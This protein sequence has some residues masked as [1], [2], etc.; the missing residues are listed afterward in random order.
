[1]VPSLRAGSLLGR[2]LFCARPQLR[3]YSRTRWCPERLK[4][5][6][7]VLTTWEHPTKQ[8]NEQSNKKSSPLLTWQQMTG[9][10]GHRLFSLRMIR[11]ENDMVTPSSLTTAPCKTT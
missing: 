3:A 2:D 6:C 11:Q 8:A 4:V 5:N 9:W 7:A 1:M 10:A